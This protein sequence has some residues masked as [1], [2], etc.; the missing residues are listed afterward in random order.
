MTTY[1]TRWIAVCAN[2]LLVLHPHSAHAAGDGHWQPIEGLPAAPQQV[3]L[4]D[5]AF[6]QVRPPVDPLQGRWVRIAGRFRGEPGEVRP[7]VVAYTGATRIVSFAPPAICR[8]EPKDRVCEAVAWIPHE[9]DLVKMTVWSSVTPTTVSELRY[10]V[11]ATGQASAEAST[12]L[13]DIVKT[14]TELYYRSAE[15]NWGELRRRVEPALSAPVG[16]DPVPSIVAVL[17]KQLPGGRHNGMLLK[18]PQD[19]EQDGRVQPMDTYMPACR[20][21]KDGI[22]LL[23]LPGTP[24][25]GPRDE[26]LYVETAQQCLLAQPNRTR[27]IVDLRNCHGGSSDVAIAALS[28]L[29]RNGELLQ[30]QNGQGRRFKV[31]L[32]RAG[33]KTGGRF[34]LERK[35]PVGKR[36]SAPALVWIGPGT[37]SA[38]EAL[39]AALST[40]SGTSL[41]GLPSAGLATGNETVEISDRY[42]MFLTAGRMLVGGRTLKDDRLAPAFVLEDAQPAQ[43]TSLFDA[44]ARRSRR[45]ADRMPEHSPN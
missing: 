27:W 15:V 14:M 38:C 41:V 36:S 23:D 22:H 21:I 12:K 39:A 11:G 43:L 31:E 29:L 10:E 28:P 4:D 24:R 13:D 3:V 32:S 17:L 18:Q 7:T 35:L 30:W 34:S 25:S 16:V 37:G 5:P 42:Q 20:F 2:L 8:G 33:V 40:R 19:P 26:G 1:L 44:I 9:A 6:H 45:Q